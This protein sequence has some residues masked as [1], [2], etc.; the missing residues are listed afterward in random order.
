MAERVEKSP[1]RKVTPQIIDAFIAEL[2]KGRN[3]SKNFNGSFPSE[4]GMPSISGE[5]SCMPMMRILQWAYDYTGAITALQDLKALVAKDAVEE[6]LR[7]DH[8]PMFR[9]VYAYI[10]DPNLIE[11]EVAHLNEWAADNK[12]RRP[13]AVKEASSNQMKPQTFTDWPKNEAKNWFDK[14]VDDWL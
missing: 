14:F 2:N 3:A 11:K 5:G 4:P 6:N 13:H 9:F 12:A 10:S 1:E 8:G 7:G